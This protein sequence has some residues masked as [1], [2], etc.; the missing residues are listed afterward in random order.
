MGDQKVETPIDG[1]SQNT[2]GERV[3]DTSFHE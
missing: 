2:V 3:V 1:F